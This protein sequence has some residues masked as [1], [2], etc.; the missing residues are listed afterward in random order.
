[1]E[2]Y[3]K[4][5]FIKQFARFVLSGGLAGFLGI[6]TIYILVD[7][8]HL[9]YLVSSI[10]AFF[11]TFVAAFFL[12]KF[13]TFKNYALFLLPKQATFSFGIAVLNFFLNTFLMY[14]LVDRLSLNYLFSQFL[15]YIFFGVVDFYIYKF[16]IFKS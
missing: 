9:W 10:A 16:V 2:Y 4:L 6:F 8:L 1:M 12:Q 5:G 7:L 3:N 15:T 13:W 11:V 14:G